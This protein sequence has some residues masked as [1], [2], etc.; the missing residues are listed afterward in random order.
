IIDT[1]RYLIEYRGTYLVG[2]I[3][4]IILDFVLIITEL[5]ISHYLLFFIARWVAKNYGKANETTILNEV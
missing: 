5:L 4:A 2:E 3:L 1:V